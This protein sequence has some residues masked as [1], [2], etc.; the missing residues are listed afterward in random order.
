MAAH[1]FTAIGAGGQN[2]FLL[3]CGSLI[4]HYTQILTFRRE[5]VLLLMKG[6]N[7]YGTRDK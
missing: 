7:G 2:P 1:A 5:S 3:P 6:D 4:G